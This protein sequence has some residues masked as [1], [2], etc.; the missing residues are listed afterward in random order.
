MSPKDSWD[1][2]DG[3]VIGVDSPISRL[4]D[5]EPFISDESVEDK[6]GHSNLISTRV[7]KKLYRDILNVLD[8]KGSP[9][10]NKSELTRDALY[11]GMLVISMRV[12]NSQSWQLS[13]KIAQ[14]RSRI[15][16][17]R[18]VSDQCD[19][20]CRDLEVVYASNHEQAKEDLTNLLDVIESAESPS[21]VDMY[22]DLLKARLSGIRLNELADMI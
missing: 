1:L 12:R 16:R 5:L 17:H 2:D 7:H 15:E 20:I 21:D 11:L 22:H 14:N 8:S 10:A 13:L 4:V 6:H 18:R 9:Y 3:D 19:E